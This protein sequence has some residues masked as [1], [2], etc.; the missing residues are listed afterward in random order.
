MRLSQAARDRARDI[1]WRDVRGFGNIVVHDYFGIDFEKVW[2]VVARDLPV[3]K[4]ALLRL[5]AEPTA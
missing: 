3:L 1:P 2:L 5:Q 4:D